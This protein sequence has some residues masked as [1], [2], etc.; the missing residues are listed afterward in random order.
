MLI[1]DRFFRAGLAR[2]IAPVA[3]NCEKHTTHARQLHHDVSAGVMKS[4]KL[5]SS[6]LQRRAFDRLLVSYRAKLL[7]RIY[8]VSME[9]KFIPG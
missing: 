9:M 5:Q 3:K 2:D 7:A 1:N 8:S 6:T 4:H